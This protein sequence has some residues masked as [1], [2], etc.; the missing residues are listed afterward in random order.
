MHMKE[1]VSSYIFERGW[2]V[3]EKSEPQKVEEGR[4]VCM[5]RVTFA[6]EKILV[7]LGGESK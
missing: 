7:P 4:V 1:I 2:V 6:R 5:H 3:A